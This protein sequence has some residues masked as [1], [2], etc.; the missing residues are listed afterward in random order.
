[1]TRMPSWGTPPPPP[2]IPVPASEEEGSRAE[3][4]SCC[5]GIPVWPLLSKRFATTSK[6]SSK[7]IRVNCELY[8]QS[9]CGCHFNQAKGFKE[10]HF[11]QAISEEQFNAN[12]PTQVE[13]CEA[14]QRWRRTSPHR[15]RRRRRNSLQRWFFVRPSVRPSFHSRGRSLLRR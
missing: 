4:F 6:Q 8:S 5:C 14:W 10:H 11:L 15:R 13:Y 12:N 9:H 2:P 1:M 7:R 3:G